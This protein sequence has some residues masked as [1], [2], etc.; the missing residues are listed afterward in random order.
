MD[1]SSIFAVHCLANTTIL[2][3]PQKIVIVN[4]NR[5][6]VWSYEIT[7]QMKLFFGLVI[8]IDNTLGYNSA[9]LTVKVCI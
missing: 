4:N 7:T 5:K 8:T 6:K 1:F 3:Y 9:S 2:F